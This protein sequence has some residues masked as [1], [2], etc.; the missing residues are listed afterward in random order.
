MFIQAMSKLIFQDD[1]EAVVVERLRIYEESTR[2]VIE[3]YR[4]LHSGKRDLV[5]SIEITGGF[6]VMAPLFEKAAVA[7]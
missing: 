2:P 1:T 5:R 7:K 4:S 3:F 6:N